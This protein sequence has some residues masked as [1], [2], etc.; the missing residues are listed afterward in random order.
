MGPV[1][2]LLGMDRTTLTAALKPLQ[3]RGLVK[4]ARDPA[5]L[6]SRILLLTPKGHELLL[7]AVP[8]WERTH[9]KID[10]LLPKQ[11][12]DQLRKGL[13]ALS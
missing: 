5:D 1:A 3:R 2:S 8:A 10:Q 6:R 7:H 13:A 11:G 4:V 9:Q 12:P